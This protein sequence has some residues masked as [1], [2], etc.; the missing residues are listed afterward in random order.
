M[1]NNQRSREK[2]ATAGNRL[3]GGLVALGL[4]LL[5]VTTVIVMCVAMSSKF[6]ISHVEQI[7]VG[8]SR[9]RVIE[10]LGEPYA[11]SENTFEYY[12]ENYL[13]LLQQQAGQ[14]DQ[15]PQEELTTARM[16][17][18]AETLGASSKVS[19]D[20][21]QPEQALGEEVYQ[22]IAV[23]FD[24][25]GVV[26]VF[27]DANRSEL[28]KEEGKEVRGGLIL[29]DALYAHT[30]CEVSYRAEYTDGSY[31][32][33]ITTVTPSAYGSTTVWWDEP[34]GG[35]CSCPVTASVNPEFPSGNGWYLVPDTQVLYI[36]ADGAS[37]YPKDVSTVTFQGGVTSIEDD[38]FSDW[39]S[40]RHITLGSGIKV[41]QAGMLKGCSSLQAINLGNGVEVVEAGTF[42]DCPALSSITIGT[43]MTTVTADAFSGCA[44]LRS[45]TIGQNVTTIE[46]GAF[47]GCDQLTSVTF[48]AADGWTA[49]GEALDVSDP[50]VNAANLLGAYGA[51][52]WT[53]TVTE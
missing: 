50:A 33:G 41:L 53:R 4:V 47:A 44:T 6:R 39:G 18:V 23:T 51:Y 26:S 2:S 27:L 12:S 9:E 29:S 10:V 19:V 15:D 3:I 14:E 21:S 48:R 45:I 7:A 38:F 22:Y 30:A 49:N 31:Y 40:L 1:S 42:A 8:D 35:R 24:E 25:D 52:A 43:G 11:R 5:F 37:G 36:F 16:P 46:A 28:T 13:R 34:Y 20:P 32:M 17:G